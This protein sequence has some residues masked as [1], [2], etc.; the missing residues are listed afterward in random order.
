MQISWHLESAPWLS[1]AQERK[2]SG[3]DMQYKD[4]ELSDVVR[5]QGDEQGAYR[6]TLQII[7]LCF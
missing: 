2:F 6:N 4:L 7:I 1:A 5:P 3:V